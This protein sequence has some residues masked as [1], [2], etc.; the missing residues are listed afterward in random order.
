VPAALDANYVLMYRQTQYGQ[1]ETFYT[2]QPIR[3]V[4]PASR[5]DRTSGFCTVVRS[6]IRA[7]L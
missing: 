1:A 6:V 7:M 3:Y 2:A 4:Q 5:A